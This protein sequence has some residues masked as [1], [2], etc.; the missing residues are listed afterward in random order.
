MKV[1][2]AIT[3]IK[4]STHDISG[5]YSTEEC[6]DFINSA[7]QQVSS[8]LIAARYPSLVQEVYLTDG[9]SVPDNYMN[10]CGTYPLKMT[11][12][13]VEIL[14]GETRVKFRYFATPKQVDE[15]DDLPYNHEAIN[16]VIVKTAVLLALNQNEYDISQDSNIV[17]A[18]QQAI[19]AG[20]A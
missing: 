4:H 20:M 13:K 17:T 15:T 14:N 9:D 6:L 2:E 19:S 7:I 8:L 11:A 10:V 5:E 3:R 16:A 18:L 1:S 12:G